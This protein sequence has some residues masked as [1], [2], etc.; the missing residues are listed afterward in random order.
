MKQLRVDCSRDNYEGEG[1]GF[2]I[3]FRDSRILLNLRQRANWSSV[4]ALER[5]RFA[6]VFVLEIIMELS[7]SLRSREKVLEIQKC[8]TG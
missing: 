7:G 4:I 1:K 6:F 8:I 2:M 5:Y 3:A